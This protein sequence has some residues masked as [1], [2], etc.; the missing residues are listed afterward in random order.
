MMPAE[1][2]NVFLP[3]GDSLDIVLA[4][5]TEAGVD[6]PL[7][8]ATV[9]WWMGHS[10]FSAGDGV[11]IKKSIGQGVAITDAT[12]T[13]SLAPSDTAEIPAGTYYHEAEIVFADGSVSTVTTG[14]FTLV[15]TIVR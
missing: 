7:A 4:V 14:R 13:V 11:L 6:V 2:Q 8:G 12:A 5:K 3:A 15:G 10:R 1:N 9:R